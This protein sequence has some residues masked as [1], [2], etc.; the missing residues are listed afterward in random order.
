MVVKPLLKYFESRTEFEL[1]MYDFFNSIDFVIDKDYEFTGHM[2]IF[3]NFN[4]VY[5]VEY[6]LDFEHETNIYSIYSEEYK[7]I[8]STSNFE[9]MLN[10]LSKIDVIKKKLRRNKIKRLL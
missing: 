7:P 1:N 2:F 5:T 3:Y 10:K 6:D 4:T 9:I 8:I